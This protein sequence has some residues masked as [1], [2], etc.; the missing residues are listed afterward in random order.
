MAVLDA[1]A[2]R[3][4]VIVEDNRATA[5]SMR[6]L[7]DLAGY[8]VRVAY[9]GPDG[10]RAAEEWRPDVVLCDIGLP[11]L[12]GYGVAAALRQRPATANA[13][14]IAITAYGSEEARRRSREVGFEE[15]FVKPVDPDV[16]LEL[17]AGAR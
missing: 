1:P 11:G 17:L 12:D 13:R 14:L 16:L 9:N 5:D 6:L 8:E 15:H 7:L 4:V 10:V 3:R 2:R